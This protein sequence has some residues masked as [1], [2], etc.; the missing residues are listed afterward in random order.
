MMITLFSQKLGLYQ[1][2]PPIDYN[3]HRRGFPYTLY[4]YPAGK[5][6]GSAFPY[7]PSGVLKVC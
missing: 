2:A 6:N 3:G 1:K 5:N 7:F 4:R